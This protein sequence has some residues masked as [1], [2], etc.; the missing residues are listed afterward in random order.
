MDEPV[1]ALK[2]VR[3]SSEVDLGAPGANMYGCQ[4][5][6]GCKSAYRCTFQREPDVIVCDDCGHREQVT[7]N[8]EKERP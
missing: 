2:V 5:C 4:P 6:P 8:F 1:K 3:K 7:R